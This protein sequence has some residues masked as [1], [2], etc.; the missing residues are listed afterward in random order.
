VAEGR[1]NRAAILARF[2]Q[3]VAQ[4]CPRLWCSRDVILPRK[5]SGNAIVALPRGGE[6]ATHLSLSARNRDFLPER[7][8]RQLHTAVDD[9]VFTRY[10]FWSRNC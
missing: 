1:K 9:A 3:Q 8:L 5:R 4:A 10:R 7:D 6:L 2:M